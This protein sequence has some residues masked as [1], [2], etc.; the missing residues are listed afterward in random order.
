MIFNRKSLPVF[1][2]LMFIGAVIGS[3]G[4]EILERIIQAAG[5]GFS[6]TLEHPIILDVHVLVISLLPNIG[7][8]LGGI[9]GVILFFLV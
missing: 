2:G 1:L 9:G 6:L 8:L 7:T 3:L 4:W 5:G